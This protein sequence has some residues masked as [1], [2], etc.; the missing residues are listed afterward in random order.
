MAFK[1]KTKELQ[2]RYYIKPLK[3]IVDFQDET[4]ILV[5]NLRDV[6]SVVL[7]IDLLSAD[8][9]TIETY[10]RETPPDPFIPTK[11]ILCLNA[12]D[13]KVVLSANYCLKQ[14]RRGR[15]PTER[16]IESLFIDNATDA[17][18]CMLRCAFPQL[19]APGE[20][21]YWRRI[22]WNAKA[23]AWA[24]FHAASAAEL[25]PKA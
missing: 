15:E 22:Q 7:K 12:Y 2:M 23:E 5:D 1:P 19:D 3:A 11:Q 8:P 16:Q 24:Q 6:P 20:T 9:N 13:L 4:V 21:G 10:V 14:L 18:R 25:Q 17:I